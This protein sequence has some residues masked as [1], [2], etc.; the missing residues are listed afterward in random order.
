MVCNMQQQEMKNVTHNVNLSK[1]TLENLKQRIS[2][3]SKD[4]IIT[5]EKNF[6]T[7]NSV[8]ILKKLKHPHIWEEQ[9]SHQTLEILNPKFD[10]HTEHIRGYHTVENAVVIEHSGLYTIF[11]Q[12]TLFS[13]VRNNQTQFMYVH[14]IS[15]NKPQ[16]SGVLLRG[17]LSGRR[18]G[19]ETVYTGGIFLLNSED[20]IQICL[21]SDIILPVDSDSSFVGLFMLE[22]R[23]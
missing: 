3:D 15:P 8:S 11:S 22:S 7:L 2:D 16:N 10:D 17:S 6:G 13:Q 14:R 23:P 19:P 1:A 12:I 20:H 18:E 21:G 5:S 9:T 4:R